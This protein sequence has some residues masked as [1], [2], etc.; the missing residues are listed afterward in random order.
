MKLKV[1]VAGLRRGVSLLNMFSHH[2][3]A[4]VV[5]VCDVDADRANSVAREH[6]IRSAY[7][8]YA[9]FVQQDLDAIVVATPATHHAEHAI[10]ALRHGKHVLSEVPAAWTLEECAALVRAVEETGQKYMLAENVCYFPHI[11][12]YRQAVANGKLGTVFYAEAEYVHDCRS[13]MRNPDGSLTWRAGMPPIH[14]CTH[15]L[16]PILFILNDRCVSA[17]GLHTGCHVAPELG[18]ID[19]E[20]GIFKLASG[21]V[22]KILCGFSVVREPAMH[23]YCLYGTAG[24]LETGRGPGE[25]AKGY[26]AAEAEA[27]MQR[28][29]IPVRP[30]EA[31]P[32]ARLG[33]HGT[34]EYFLVHDFVA[35]ILNDT[36]PPIDVYT[37]M[38]YTA[39][40]ICAHRSA[41]AG[42]EAVEVPNFR[43]GN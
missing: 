26:F 35:S 11:E 34:S 12:A 6:N 10:A 30:R 8:D 36:P 19:M 39:P 4:E 43:P 17:S 5:A 32:E 14:Y 21:A 25:P 37:G 13:L 2:P 42:G 33:G 18:A 3:Q 16:G 1:G 23:W 20:V 29:P 22:V 40:G 15:S 38:D 41:E 27:G 7:D 24:C 28:D 9:S 31:P